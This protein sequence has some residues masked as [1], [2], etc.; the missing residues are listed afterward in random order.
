[1]AWSDFVKE[2]APHSEDRAITEA[3]V[4]SKP[5]VSPEYAKTLFKGNI[6]GIQIR[7]RGRPIKTVIH[8]KADLNG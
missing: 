2:G 3:L 4:R 5:W 8:N 7:S 1:M 6:E